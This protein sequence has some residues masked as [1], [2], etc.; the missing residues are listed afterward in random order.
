M[1]K[2]LYQPGNTACVLCLKLVILSPL[3]QVMDRDSFSKVNWPSG[4]IN[5]RAKSCHS[6]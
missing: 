6:R 1:W 2:M 3:A 5:Q 4:N